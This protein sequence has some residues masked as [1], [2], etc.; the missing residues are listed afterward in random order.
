MDKDLHDWQQ[1]WQKKE[2][3]YSDPDRL[4]NTLIRLEK[5]GRA[6]RVIVTAL[7]I[8][9][10]C[11]F[12]VYLSTQFLNMLSIG[13]IVLGMLIVLVPLYRN[14][15]QINK[16]NYMLN[17]LEFKDY[18]IKLLKR[19][20]LIPKAYMVAFIVLFVLALNLAFWESFS[21]YS[22]SL[23]IVLHGFTG[24]IL[25]LLIRV[26]SYGIRMYSKEIFP[27]IKKIEN[28]LKD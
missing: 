24:V 27:L 10:L 2:S 8:F 20:L 5:I 26:R 1:L 12:Y 25:L 16:S 9:A 6:Q 28:G 19:K 4:I 23:R 3:E 18:T 22:M 15:I 13:L 14:R 17:T 21:E 11:M 7:F